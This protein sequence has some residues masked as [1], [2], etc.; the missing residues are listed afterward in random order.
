MHYGHGEPTAADAAE[1]ER[2]ERVAARTRRV[3][4]L[5]AQGATLC[6]RPGTTLT[7]A[8]L[9]VAEWFTAW[10]AAPGCVPFTGCP[11]CERVTSLDLEPGQV[12][13][14]GQHSY[15]RKGESR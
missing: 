8:D 13:S 7:D 1:R 3:E 14:C 12:A 9:D 5:Q 15:V 11:Q 6:T 2:W 4:A 10:L